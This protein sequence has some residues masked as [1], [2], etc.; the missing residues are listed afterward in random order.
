MIFVNCPNFPHALWRFRST[1]GQ[2]LSVDNN[3]RP[4]YRNEETSVSGVPYDEKTQ[5]IYPSVSLT[6]NLLRLLSVPRRHIY[7]VGCA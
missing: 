1:S 6:S 3:V 2:S 7:E 5:P 4:K